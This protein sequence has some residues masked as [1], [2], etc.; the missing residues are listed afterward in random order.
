[1]WKTQAKAIG[2][3]AQWVAAAPTLKKRADLKGRTN[4]EGREGAEKKNPA[5]IMPKP[6]NW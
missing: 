5:P 3:T 6:A 2:S 1:M 4:G